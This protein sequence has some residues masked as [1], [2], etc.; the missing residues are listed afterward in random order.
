MLIKKKTVNV[1]FAKRKKDVF[2]HMIFRSTKMKKFYL[3]VV[4]VCWSV[5]VGEEKRM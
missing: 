3:G 5:L 1:L 4:Y 2:L